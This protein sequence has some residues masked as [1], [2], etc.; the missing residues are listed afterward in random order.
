[1]GNKEAFIDLLNRY[2]SNTITAE[3]EQAFLKMVN[4]HADDPV[5]E[6]LLWESYQQSGE[7]QFWSDEYRKLFAERIMKRIQDDIAIPVT[8]PVVAL[9]SSRKRFAI[10]AAILVLIAAGAYLWLQPKPAATKEMKSVA[11]KNEIMP[12]REGAVLTLGDGS[13]LVLDSMNKG[14]VANEKGATVLLDKGLLSYD[15]VESPVTETAWNTMTTPRGRQFQLILPDGSKVWLNAGSSLRYPTSFTTNERMV[16]LEGEAY[17]EI[18]KNAGK[19]FKVQTPD[20]PEVEVLGTRF[21]IN[22]YKNEKVI[23][24]TLLEGMV[25][26]NAFRQSLVLKPRQQASTNAGEQSTERTEA[27][28][29]KVMAWK[30]GYFD[31]N[32]EELPLVLRQVERWYDI[33]VQ[34]EGD[35]PDMTF[36]GKMDRKV[37]LSDVINSLKNLGINTRLENRTLVILGKKS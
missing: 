4:E 23:A 1:M 26:V 12:G 22:A 17:F 5:F 10:A 24:T 31:F 16:E 27:D 18:E 30:N 20:G 6:D 9:G 33:D 25:R 36:K 28:I 13:K 15:A 34:Y 7:M 32:N 11:A 14:I 8:A 19:P 21:N 37:Q 3:E 35:I 2:L 29:N